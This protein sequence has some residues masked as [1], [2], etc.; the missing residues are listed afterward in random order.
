[1]KKIVMTFMSLV[2]FFGM[3]E[4]QNSVSMSAVAL[5]P[6]GTATLSIDVTNEVEFTAFVLT[7][8]LPDGITIAEAL[9]EDDEL[10]PDVALTT[11]KKSDHTVSV[12][13]AN[14]KIASFSA[15]NK[16]FRDA[17]GTLVT[18]TLQASATAKGG[19]YPITI[20]DAALTDIEG[21]DYPMEDASAIAVVRGEMTL[22]YT[23][24]DAGWGT[25]IVPFDHSLPTGLTAYTC[26]GYTTSEGLNWLT[27]AKATTLAAN[28]PYIVAGAA[29]TYELTGTPSV[30]NTTY[31][32]GLLTGVYVPTSVAEGYVLQKQ[33]EEVAF[34]Q[35]AEDSPK[36]V[37]A[38]RCYMGN[39]P[40]GAIA[41]RLYG[42]TGVKNL[43]K[44]EAGML[45]DLQGR[46]F[47]GTTE[48]GIYIRNGKLI[49][50]K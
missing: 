37:P 20:A 2:A 44:E 12:N 6:G 19:L 35:I 36:T 34:F 10:A 24:T 21:T 4:A 27:L 50:V 9:N 45:Y 38:Y 1:M 25:L 14:G 16:T 7:L 30:A 18:V 3:A 28:T 5:E 49:M 42:A 8:N 39:A 41:F 13:V 40:S 29:G 23:M 46:G 43:T 31:S 17:S 11:R 33:S 22:S 26:D 47:E 32:E 15:T 48:D